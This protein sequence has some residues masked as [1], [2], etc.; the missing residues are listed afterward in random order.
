MP[1][2]AFGLAPLGQDVAVGPEPERRRQIGRLVL[3]HHEDIDAGQV[4]VRDAAGRCE[5]EDRAKA[6]FSGQEGRGFAL[7]IG[8]FALQEEQAA[9]GED[10]EIPSFLRRLAN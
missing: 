4:G 10:L 7:S 8:N 6:G 2:A 5:V 3:V 9:E 1:F